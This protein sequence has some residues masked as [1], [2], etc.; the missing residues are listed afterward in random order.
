MPISTA[1]GVGGSLIG[2][3][4]AAYGAKKAAGQQKRAALD[5]ARY[6]ADAARRAEETWR[7]ATDDSLAAWRDGTDKSVGALREFYDKSRGFYDQSRGDIAGA[8][9]RAEGYLQP[10]RDAGA[11]ALTTLSS[12]YGNPDSF[13][14]KFKS[15]PD[16][17]FRQRAGN[18]ALQNQLSKASGGRGGNAL[19]DFMSFG[20]GLA[21]E[22]LEGYKRTVTGLA[23]MGRG[24]AAQ[25]G[26]FAMRTGG[27]LGANA[28]QFA[29]MTANTGASLGNTYMRGAEGL[30][31]TYMRGAAGV[32][33]AQQDYGN[34][35]G[36]GFENAGAAN[37]SGTVGMFNAL[38]QGFSGAA[39]NY[40][41]GQYMKQRGGPGGQFPSGWDWGGSSNFGGAYGGGWGNSGG[42][43][44]GHTL[45]GGYGYV[46]G[47]GGWDTWWNRFNSGSKV[48]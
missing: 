13:Y 45:G 37:A 3:G 23:D 18:E 31:N 39:N 2:G 33:G 5:G 16:Y 10:Y 29:S 25:S 6:R 44:G 24:A 11:G 41:L 7:G 48:G 9:A 28:G 1:I 15:S 20:Q 40:T 38:G 14:E 42:W 46:P 8:G 35:W 47:G 4:L 34:A 19:K 36:Q 17:Q 27:T 21:T 22:G 30:G 32:A 43:G 12:L 26:E